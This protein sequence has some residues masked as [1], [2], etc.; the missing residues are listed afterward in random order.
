[1]AGLDEILNGKHPISR[2]Q[3]ICQQWKFPVPVYRESQGSLSQFAS[4]VT[5]TV[6]ET[7]LTFKGMGRTKKI[8]KTRAAEEA[9]TFLAETKSHVL[10][11]PPE[12][13]GNTV[14]MS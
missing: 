12:P 6:E 3:E 7:T 9:L 11:P 10:E 5:L 13:V 2:L 1:M 14:Q 4:E 8:G